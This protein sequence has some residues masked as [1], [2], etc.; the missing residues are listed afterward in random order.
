[1][2]PLSVTEAP[3][4]LDFID[5]VATAFVLDAAAQLSVINPV[6]RRSQDTSQL[7]DA[8]A[9]DPSM[10]ALLLQ[11]FASSAEDTRCRSPRS[12]PSTARAR[13]PR[14]GRTGLTRVHP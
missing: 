7:V 4:L 6:A 14:K 1:M 2:S 5:A 10:T 9:T 13:S 11:R 8:C 3:L 12:L